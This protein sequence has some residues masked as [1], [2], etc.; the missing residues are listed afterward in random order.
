V[1]VYSCCVCVCVC[2]CVCMCVCV[3]VR[4][5]LRACTSVRLFV[6]VRASVL[7][8]VRMCVYIRGEGVFVVAKQ[9]EAESCVNRHSRVCK[10]SRDN[11]C[12]YKG[13]GGSVCCCKTA[14][15]RELC[16]KAESVK[17]LET[18][19]VLLPAQII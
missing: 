6:C 17:N 7:A 8:S 1:C 2:V 5:C 13:G 9:Q 12:V 10:N 11:V 18:I 19:P 4:V 16:E 3:C 14:G 15:N